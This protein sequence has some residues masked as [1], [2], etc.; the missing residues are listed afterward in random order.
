MRRVI[1]FA[2]AFTERWNVVSPRE[3]CSS[4]QRSHDDQ[5]IRPLA[6]SALRDNPVYHVADPS[7]SEAMSNYIDN[8]ISLW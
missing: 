3:G 7:Q 1:E 4:C 6:G 2:G 8:Q 5:Q